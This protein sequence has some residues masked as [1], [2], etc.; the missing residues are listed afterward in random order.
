MIDTELKE[1]YKKGP[2]IKRY[3]ATLGCKTIDAEDIFKKLF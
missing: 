2:Q 1:V 3:L